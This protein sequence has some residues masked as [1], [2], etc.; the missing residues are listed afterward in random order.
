MPLGSIAFGQGLASGLDFRSIV[1]AI[2]EAER[3]PTRALQRRIDSFTAA[4]DRVQELSDLLTSF[5]GSLEDLKSSSTIGGKTA[6][7]SDAEAGLSVSV[8]PSADVGSYSIEVTQ[9]AQAH[10]IRSDGF[11]DRYSPLVGDGTITIQSGDNELITIDVSA[12]NGNNSLQAIA[13]AINTADEGVVASI[14]NDGTS[15]ILIVRAENTGADNSLT[16]TDTTNLNLTDPANELQAAQDAELTVDGVDITSASNTVGGAIKGVTL[17]LMETTIGAVTLTI[18]EDVDGAKQALRDFVEAYNEVSEYFDRQFGTAE[19]QRASGLAG[20]TL[21]RNVQRQIQGLLTGRVTGIPEGNIDTLA[22]L[23]IVVADGTGRLEFEESTFD[24]L[25]EQGRFDEVRAV[26]QSTGSTTDSAIVYLGAGSKT[27]AGTYDIFVTQAA[28]RADVRGKF[29]VRSEGIDN[30]ETLTITLNDD[31][32]DV[33]L[34]TGDTI[35]VI[36][37]RINDALS[38]AGMQASA[39]SDSDVLV[40][41][42]DEYGSAYTLTAVSDRPATGAGR[43]TGIG[44][45][46]ITDTGV[47]VAGTI[48]GEV[49]E[50]VGQVLIGPDDTDVDGLRVRV[51]ATAESIAAKG[52]DFGSVGYSEGLAERFIDAIDGITDP[53]EGTIKSI[54]DGFEESIESLELKIERVNERLVR[55]EELLIRQFAA[56]EQAISQLQL[57]QATL[58][59]RLG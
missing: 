29:A 6:T 18:G 48:G 43:S 57:F 22:E 26:I 9:L 56:A 36:V 58:Q 40:I 55:R 21:V 20:N 44:K 7:L 59:Q 46:P 39:R 52:G 13:D 11:T 38:A 50:G 32:I 2:L 33:G 41:E 3:F 1:N 31:T 14:I 30:D 45:R 5:N 15:D 4:R 27:V 53:F 17:T 28:E 35:D 49:A 8:N 34:T 23:G 24:D 12:D 47:D 51:Y 16:I 54:K 25:V 19:F 10:R 37:G 42:A